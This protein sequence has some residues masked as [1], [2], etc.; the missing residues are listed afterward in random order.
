MMQDVPKRRWDF[1]LG[2]FLIFQMAGEIP[3]VRLEI[4]RMTAEVQCSPCLIEFQF[5]GPPPRGDFESS[6]TSLRFNCFWLLST[7]GR[8]L[9]AVQDSYVRR[10]S[11]TLSLN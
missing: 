4:C 8:K 6:I 5:F 9:A 7:S 2:Y 3:G 10:Y 1:S 11:D